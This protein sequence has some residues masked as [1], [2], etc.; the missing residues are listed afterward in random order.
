[1]TD[2]QSDGP[3]SSTET[4]I[5]A[6]RIIVCD[7]DNHTQF[8]VENLILYSSA[9]REAADRLGELERYD[10]EFKNVRKTVL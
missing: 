6:L 2:K 10:K 7:L 1:M 4:I 5:E 8:T 3:K 9:L